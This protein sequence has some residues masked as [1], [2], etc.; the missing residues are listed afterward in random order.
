M[1]FLTPNDAPADYIIRV[2]KIPFS[3]DWLALV[4]GALSPLFFSSAWEKHG[5]MT[6]GEASEVAKTIIQQ[7]FYEGS[8]LIGGLV[9]YATEEPPPMVLPCDGSI[10]DGADYPLLYARLPSILKVGAD[11]F[12]TPNLGGRFI[13]GAGEGDGFGSAAERDPHIRGGSE[14]V[15]LTE[16]QMPSHNHS[17]NAA[18]SLN[19]IN[20]GSPDTTLIQSI[21]AVEVTNDA[22]GDEPH[23]NMPPFY[24]LKYGIIFA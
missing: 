2:L 8:G 21:V 20:T 14:D 18:F 3:R 22:G 13:L 10:Y 7:S 9:P 6:P 16:A 5:D 11:Q 4:G 12:R 17:I 1:P 23:N 24:A 15:T 19:P